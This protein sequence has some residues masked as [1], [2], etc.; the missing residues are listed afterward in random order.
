LLAPERMTCPSLRSLSLASLLVAGC[1]VDAVD[2]GGAPDAAP[3]GADA[4]VSSCTVPQSFGAVTALGN[5][6]ASQANQQ[7]STELKVYRLSGRLDDAE[8]R[9]ALQISLFDGVGVFAG[10]VAEPGTY[11]LAGAETRFDTCGACV[12]VIGDI[13]PGMGPTQFFIAQSGT[14]QIDSIQGTMSGTLTGATFAEFE[15]GSSD[16]VAGGC[17]TAIDSVPFSATVQIIDP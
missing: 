3:A 4:D 11:T 9:D 2:P 16:L 10:G 1:A 14:L 13:V 8:I 5:L 7:G 15:L 12:T 6:E 17:Q